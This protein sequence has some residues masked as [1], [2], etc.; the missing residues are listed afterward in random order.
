MTQ[1][2]VA[3]AML[4]VAYQFAAAYGWPAIFGPG[5]LDLD[6]AHAAPPSSTWFLPFNQQVV[7]FSQGAYGYP[8]ANS[9]VVW[10]FTQHNYGDVAHNTVHDYVNSR[11][12][13]TYGLLT[14]NWN[15]LVWLTEGGFEPGSGIIV[16]T[17]ADQ[18]QSDKVAD[19]FTT[20]NDLNL[21]YGS[22]LAATFPNYTIW[23]YAWD[24]HFAGMVDEWERDPTTLALTT[25]GAARKLLSRWSSL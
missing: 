15:G 18:T 24:P 5:T 6:S 7:A 13:T 20:M 19:G 4:Y 9:P 21:A 1:A 2:Y 8:P 3:S 23:N 10:G 11:T 12:Y 14:A 16:G 17:G 25:V 22:S